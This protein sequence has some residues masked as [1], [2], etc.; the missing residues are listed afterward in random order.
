MSDKR[1]LFK[2]K[3]EPE[4][5]MADP[6]HTLS[7]ERDLDRVIAL[8]AQVNTNLLEDLDLD[9]SFDEFMKVGEA[10][11]ITSIMNTSMKT[12]RR[13]D[14]DNSGKLSLVETLKVVFPTVSVP[15]IKVALQRRRRS[16]ERDRDL[17][18]VRAV[19]EDLQDLF[20]HLDTG[21]KGYLTLQDLKKSLR[22]V[23]DATMAQ[24]V[25]DNAPE[26]MEARR[27]AYWKRKEHTTLREVLEAAHVSE[28]TI[29]FLEDHKVNVRRLPHVWVDEENLSEQLIGKM[30]PGEGER[31]QAVISM[32]R[33]HGSAAVLAAKWPHS[34]SEPC[35]VGNYS[36]TREAYGV[37]IHPEDVRLSIQG[38]ARLMDSHGFNLESE[39]QRRNRKNVLPFYYE[40]EIAIAARKGESDTANKAEEMS[41]KLNPSDVNEGTNTIAPPVED[42]LAIQRQGVP[43]YHSVAAFLKAKAQK[44]RQAKLA[45]EKIMW[46]RKQHSSPT[47]MNPQVDAS[48]P[49]CLTPSDEATLEALG[50]HF[51]ARAE[52]ESRAHFQ[53][54]N[55]SEVRAT[56]EVPQRKLRGSRPS[57]ILSS[58]S[59][60]STVIF[61]SRRGSNQS[62]TKPRSAYGNHKDV[63]QKCQNELI[64]LADQLARTSEFRRFDVLPSSTVDHV[65]LKVEQSA[66]LKTAPIGPLNLS[67]VQPSCPKT[68]RPQ[69]ARPP[70][71]EPRKT[72]GV[73]SSS[74]GRA[75]AMTPRVGVGAP[76]RRSAL[77][78]T[79]QRILTQTTYPTHA[80]SKAVQERQWTLTPDNEC[81]IYL[82]SLAPRDTGGM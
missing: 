19:S 21:N 49:Q 30:Q 78:T 82:S 41:Q 35:L 48:I 71:K 22:C 53:E 37:E 64:P 75:L 57:T 73:V 28:S 33:R 23:D 72:I 61:P 13:S 77:L 74:E 5:I 20:R 44:M 14:K 56:L 42:F 67:L 26:M 38:F 25:L 47:M 46:Q 31:V 70:S 39:G 43:R 12:F 81:G 62:E 24:F 59:N 29:I 76:F 3:I 9:I 4:K 54:R 79:P 15:T 18:R 10:L 65:I 45:R 63:M 8:I 32:L 36:G 51:Q 27:L 52:V 1:Y 16:L 60:A 17:H 40:F 58:H 34:L 68:P 7:F 55:R 2:K 69:S 11:K 50:I 66:S 6:R 80:W